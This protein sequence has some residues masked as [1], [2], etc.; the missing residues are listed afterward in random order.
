MCL[1]EDAFAVMLASSGHDR[2]AQTYQQKLLYKKKERPQEWC[3][4]ER[5]GFVFADGC[6]FLA[7]ALFLHLSGI[8]FSFLAFQ[9]VGAIVLLRGGG[10]HLRFLSRYSQADRLV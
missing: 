5:S 2:I 6:R 8:A 9:V 10:A 1:T 7:L 4:D 3:P